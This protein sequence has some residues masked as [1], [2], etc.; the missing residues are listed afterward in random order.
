MEQIVKCLL[1]ILTDLLEALTQSVVQPM[2]H[3]KKVTERCVCTL[4]HSQSEHV[5]TNLPS[6]SGSLAIWP[7]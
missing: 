2:G 7:P 1:E 5:P 4:N 6:H 3:G